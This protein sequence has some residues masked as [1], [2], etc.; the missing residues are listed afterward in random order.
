M[1]EAIVKY[2][3]QGLECGKQGSNQICAKLHIFPKIIKE[4]PFPERSKDHFSQF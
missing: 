2:D 4:V 1:Y 3:I